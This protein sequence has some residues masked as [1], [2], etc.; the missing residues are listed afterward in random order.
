MNRIYQGKVAAVEIPDGKDE[1]GKPF[2]FHSDIARAKLLAERIPLLRSKVDDEM[3][4]RSK[5]SQGQRQQKPESKDLQE[6]R[7]L[8]AEQEREWQNAVWQHHELFQDAV[9]YYTLAIVA[10]GSGLPDDHPITKLRERMRTAWDEFPKKTPTPAISLGQSLRQYLGSDAKMTFDDACKWAQSHGSP[11]DG[12][13]GAAI[14]AVC[15]RRGIDV[16]RICHAMI[17]YWVSAIGNF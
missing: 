5:M 16:S 12:S 7:A 1:Q 14:V 2:I 4:A 6:Y 13:T 15:A 3:K 9:N 8:R 17:G 11:D 10:L